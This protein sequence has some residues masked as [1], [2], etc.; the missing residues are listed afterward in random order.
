MAPLNILRR[1]TC[2]RGG[3]LI[4]FALVCPLLLVLVFG[5]A[6]FGLLFQRYEVLTNAAREGARVAALPGYLEPDVVARV[7]QYLAGTGI[8]ATPA[9]IAPTTVN[10][11]GT[12]CITIAGATVTYQHTFIGLGG[13][14]TLINPSGFTATKTLTVSARMRVEGGAISCP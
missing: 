10:I 12:S 5:I 11:G 1:L 13:I 7:N 8:S 6:N 4:E 14:M 2:D 3:N 9:Y